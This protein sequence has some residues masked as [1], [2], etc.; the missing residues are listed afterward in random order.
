MGE[1]KTGT[2]S[3]SQSGRHIVTSTCNKHLPQTPVTGTCD[4]YWSQAPAKTV[5]S[6]KHPRPLEYQVFGCF[7]ISSYK[8]RNIIQMTF[9]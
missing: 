3:D 7:A 8:I 1:G 5:T 2:H 4:K 9:T 6:T